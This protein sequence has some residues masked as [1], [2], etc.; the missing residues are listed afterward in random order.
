MAGHLLAAGHQVMVWN[1]TPTK[2]EPLKQAGAEV[3]PDLAEV[4]RHCST[5][6]LCV[7]RTEDVREC[8]AE[9]AQTASPGTLFVDH[10]T[11]SPVGAV[12][13]AGTLAERGFRFMD[14]PITGGSMGAQKGTLT[15]FCGGSQGD[16]EEAQPLMQ[17]YGKTVARVGEVGKGQLTKMANQIAVGGALIGLAESL[18]F[19]EKAGLD[20][21]QTQQLLARGA[22]GSWAFDNYGPK[23]LDHDWSP[24]FSVKNQRK[25]FS[26][27]REAA[28]SIN[29][30]IPSTALV[31]A[32]LA[33]LEEE[34]SGELATAALFETLC[35]MDFS[36]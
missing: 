1:R 33:K 28:G 23:I 29:A 2:A 13:I 31:D 12:E 8:L 16:F 15:I 4:G 6:F 34:G 25:D 19:A 7:N 14:A 9:M 35:S 22:A 24:G 11:I 30:A 20:L 17:S 5:V 10:S 32:L 21:A 27:C 18:S 36:E 26:Y 3:A